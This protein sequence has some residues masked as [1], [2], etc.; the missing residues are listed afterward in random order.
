MSDKTCQ[1]CQN[2]LHFA[3]RY[4]RGQTGYGSN[5]FCVRHGKQIKG[6]GCEGKDWEP[7]FE[8]TSKSISNTR[9]NNA[10]I[11]YK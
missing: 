10:T 2:C 1:N 4:I 7:K 9:D 8:K 3:F 5:H 11:R 6:K